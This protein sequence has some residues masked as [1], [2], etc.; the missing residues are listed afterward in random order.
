MSTLYTPT[1]LN[2]ELN[3]LLMLGNLMLLSKICYY[4]CNILPINIYNSNWQF[5]YCNLIIKGAFSV[6]TP[7]LLFKVIFSPP[8]IL[9]LIVCPVI[10]NLHVWLFKL[11]SWY[12][13]VLL[14]ELP[15]IT[16]NKS[17][18]V[19]LYL[20]NKSPIERITSIFINTQLI[21]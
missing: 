10:I 3:Y 11:N 13:L 8:L 12:V 21:F 19:M 17:L 16:L 1:I 7:K 2:S 4:M 14:Y 6:M 15:D 18:D 20:D 5:C 9:P